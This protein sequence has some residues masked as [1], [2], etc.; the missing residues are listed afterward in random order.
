L[1]HIR[2]KI[3]GKIGAL[4]IQG[5]VAGKAEDGHS[6]SATG[7]MWRVLRDDVGVV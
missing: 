6:L 4:I 1:I 5:D 3:Y 2:A 7:M